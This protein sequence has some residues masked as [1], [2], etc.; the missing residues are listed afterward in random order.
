MVAKGASKGIAVEAKADRSIWTTA[1][2][3]GA[4][5]STRC[6]TAVARPSAPVQARASIAP[7]PRAKR[8]LRGKAD[9][10]RPLDQALICRG[11]FSGVPL[12]MVADGGAISNSIDNSSCWMRWAISQLLDATWAAGARAVGWDCAFTG[13]ARLCV[14]ITLRRATAPPCISR[15]PRYS[16]WAI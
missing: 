3:V 8:Q 5:L 4:P 11:I 6:S 9:T 1:V 13:M 15:S 12:L 2:C 7:R 10:G 14:P 16:D